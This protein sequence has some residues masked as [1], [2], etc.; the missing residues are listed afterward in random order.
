MTEYVNYVHKRASLSALLCISLDRKLVQI[1]QK[2]YLAIEWMQ[3]I[4]HNTKY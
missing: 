1:T 3:L 2:K 4:I